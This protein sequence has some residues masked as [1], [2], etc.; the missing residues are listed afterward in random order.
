MHKLYEKLKQEK[1]N[2]LIEKQIYN[3][4]IQARKNQI[5]PMEIGQLG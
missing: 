3:W 1:Q 2:R 4:D 5:P